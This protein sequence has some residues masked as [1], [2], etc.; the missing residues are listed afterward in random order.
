VAQFGATHAGR[1][2]RHEH[3]A[4]EQIAGRVDEPNRFFLSKDDGKATG[5]FRVRY[6][7]HRIVAFQRLAEEEAQRR[8]VIAH[9]AYTLLSLVQQ[10]HLITTDLIWPELIRRSMKMFREVLDCFDVRGY[11]SLRVISTLEL[12][13]HHLA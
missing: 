3:S 2:Q 12:F 10:I 7:L 9:R 6:F 13:Q 8:R 1:V 11:G 4:M 5:R